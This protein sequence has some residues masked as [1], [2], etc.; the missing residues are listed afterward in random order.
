MTKTRKPHGERG[1]DRNAALE[2]TP[3]RPMAVTAPTMMAKAS[4]SM[5]P[6]RSPRFHASEKPNGATKQAVSNSVAASKIEEGRADGDLFA[7][8]LLERERVERAEQN[9]RACGREQ[10]IVDDESALARN[11]SEQSALA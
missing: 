10:Q 9:R 1:E 4:L 11:R 5:T 7:G 8:Q 6:S 2:A 3:R